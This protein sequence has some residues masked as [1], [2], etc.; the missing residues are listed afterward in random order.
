MCNFSHDSRY[1]YTDDDAKDPWCLLCLIA[2]LRKQNPNLNAADAAR[3]L[4]G[5][6]C[7]DPQIDG[8]IGAVLR[9]NDAVRR[10]DL[11]R[12]LEIVLENKHLKAEIVRLQKI[13]NQVDDV[14][15]INWVG[16]RVDCDYRQA[17]ADLADLVSINI[18]QHEYFTR[19]AA[20]EGKPDLLL[21]PV[22]SWPDG[23]GSKQ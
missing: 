21:G 13:V 8:E 14:L 9:E 12:A 22:D 23:E 5:T 18:S 15:V 4:K 11:V 16:P 1:L 20:K 7:C 10:G 6:Q 2:D 19:E 17:L 3:S